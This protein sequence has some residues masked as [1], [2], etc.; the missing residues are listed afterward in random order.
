MTEAAYLAFDRAADVKHI[1]WDGE[2]FAMAGASLAHNLIVGNLLRQL[3]NRLPEGCR[4][5]PS[6]IRVRLPPSDRYV[7]PDV[8]I[9]CGRPRVEGDQD[10]LLNPTTILEVLS[11][12]T[13]AF[14]RGDKFDAYTRIPTLTEILLVSQEERRIECFSRQADDSW[15][16]RVYRGTTG[17]V[18]HGLPSPIPLDLIYLDVE[19]GASS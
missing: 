11:P 13:E 18:I 8:T 2:V 17:A 7:Y 10:I 6:D 14:D 4:A 12:S 16:R 15:L 5:L 3:G 1:L 19:L 9:V